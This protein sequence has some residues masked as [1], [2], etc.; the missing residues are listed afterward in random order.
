MESPDS[1]RIS[2]GEKGFTLLT[3]TILRPMSPLR[4][5]RSGLARRRS[6]VDMGFTMTKFRGWSSVSHGVFFQLF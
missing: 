3:G 6:G 4:G 2:Q 5:I 1:G